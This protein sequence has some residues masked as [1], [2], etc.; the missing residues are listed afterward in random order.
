VP[1]GGSMASITPGRN[2]R[3]SVARPAGAKT[4]PAQIS[5][6]VIAPQQARPRVQQG[7]RLGTRAVLGVQGFVPWTST[8]AEDHCGYDRECLL[9]D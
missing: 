8:E 7:K 2:L 5:Q 9:A 4:R 3:A 1:L 6:R